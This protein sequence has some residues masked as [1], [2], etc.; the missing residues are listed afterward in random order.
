MNP[1]DCEVCKAKTKQEYRQ[2]LIEKIKAGM[3]KSGKHIGR[4]Y[5]QRTLNRIKK[6]GSKWRDQDEW[7]KDM[8]RLE[9]RGVPASEAITWVRG[10]PTH[11]SEEELVSAMSERRKQRQKQE[12]IK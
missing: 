8:R 12:E 11:L 2:E 9:S 3:R 4:P 5:C 1:I 6:Y 10:E 7:L